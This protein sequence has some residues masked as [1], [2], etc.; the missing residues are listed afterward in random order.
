[1]SRPFS[2]TLIMT[3]FFF[4]LIDTW[5]TINSSSEEGEEGKGEKGRG[6]KEKGEE[7]RGGKGSFH[8]LYI[9]MQLTAQL[10]YKSPSC[11]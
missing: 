9:M 8:H 5:E 2:L 3:L 1:M 7:S 11:S 4:M 6:G 10:L